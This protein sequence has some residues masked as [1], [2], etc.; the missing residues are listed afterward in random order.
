L[1]KAGQ[2]GEIEFRRRLSDYWLQWDL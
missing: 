2:I 1:L